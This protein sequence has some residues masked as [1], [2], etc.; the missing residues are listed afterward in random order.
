MLD[1][2]V[3]WIGLLCSKGE[4]ERERERKKQAQNSDRT[5]ES[6]I[7]LLSR[8]NKKQIG[9][10]FQQKKST[11]AEENQIKYHVGG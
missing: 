5:H 9:P 8:K 4:S 6:F 7:N 2:T 1:Q 11:Q 10:C 3:T